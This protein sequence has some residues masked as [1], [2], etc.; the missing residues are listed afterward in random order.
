MCQ[1]EL[2]DVLKTNPSDDFTRLVLGALGVELAKINSLQRTVASAFYAPIPTEPALDVS[3]LWLLQAKLD[4]L[5]PAFTHLK[6]GEAY[7]MLRN[8]KDAVESL[9][10]CLRE[11]ER[12]PYF[13][14][15]CKRL[16][17]QRLKDYLP[18]I[19]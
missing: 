9:N 18:R 19:R 12:H 13:D 14:A 8:A 2:L 6:L 5:Y 17:K 16:A 4:G 7:I 3:L 1:K 10:A 11:P 15:H